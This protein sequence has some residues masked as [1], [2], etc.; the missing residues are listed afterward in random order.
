MDAA[1][2]GCG[3]DEMVA[4]TQT[5]EARYF[6]KSM[7]SNQ[8]PQYMQHVYHVPHDGKVLYVKY[9]ADPKLKLLSFKEK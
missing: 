7:P 5:M 1:A 3:I 8:K 6:Y 2:L 4:V 9:T